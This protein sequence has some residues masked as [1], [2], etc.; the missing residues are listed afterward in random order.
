MVSCSRGPFSIEVVGVVRFTGE[1]SF[2]A[3]CATVMALVLFT[4]CAGPSYRQQVLK[5]MELRAQER[6][7]HRARVDLEQGAYEDVIRRLTRLLDRSPSTPLREEAIWLLA[8]AL[9]EHGERQQALAH[10]R[11]LAA[12]RTDTPHR[13][14]ARDRIAELERTLGAMAKERSPARVVRTAIHRHGSAPRDI[15]L[16]IQ[17]RAREGYITVLLDLGCGDHGHAVPPRSNGLSFGPSTMGDRLARWIQEATHEGLRVFVGVHL[18][19]LGMLHPDPPD[20]WRDRRY[21]PLSKTVDAS[22]FYDLFHPDYRAFLGHMLETIARHPLD[23]FVYLNEYPSGPYDG[24]S[25]WATR[26]FSRAFGAPLT[27]PALFGAD[28][29]T[30]ALGQK[31]AWVRASGLA[32]APEFWRWAGWK[33]RQRL[34]LLRQLSQRLKTSHPEL[35]FGVSLRLQGLMEPNE[36]LVCA[37]EDVL[38]TA[39]SEVDIVLLAT[40]REAQ[41]A[42]PGRYDRHRSTSADTLDQEVL[43]RFR[44][45]AG[46]TKEIW[47]DLSRDDPD[48]ATEL[49]EWIR[50]VVSSS[51]DAPFA[52]FGF[53]EQR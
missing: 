3:V 2:V 12:S 48:E 49:V 8:R 36:V 46:A 40:G 22:P 42:C 24:F 33:M 52:R 7:L 38:E 31:T 25:M 15:A 47:L 34:I 1:T 17:Q 30:Q 11:K 19:C 27:P 32:L 51:D 35:A 53:V 16:W 5:D 29:S 37:N 4:A 21:D 20:E 44:N 26:A 9:E 18:R 45:L 39:R 43:E 50:Q 14:E 23:G 41:T 10:Y 28:R 6:I 13:N